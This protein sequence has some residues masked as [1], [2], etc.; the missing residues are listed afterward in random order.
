VKLVTKLLCGVHSL[1]FVLVALPAIKEMLYLNTTSKTD[2]FA[3]LVLV[4]TVK[5]RR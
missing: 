5:K 1:A 4:V 3:V 2:M